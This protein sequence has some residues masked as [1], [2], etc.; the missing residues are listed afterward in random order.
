MIGDNDFWGLGSKVFGG[1]T[2]CNN[3]IVAPNVVVVKDVSDNC[4]VAGVPAKIINRIK[5]D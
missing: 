5:N 3:I 1:G 4:I 2:I